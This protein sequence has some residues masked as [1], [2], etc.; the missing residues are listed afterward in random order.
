MSQKYES[1]LRDSISKLSLG[2][3]DIVIVT[4]PEAMSTFVEMTQAGVGFSGYANPVLYVPGG[5][6]KATREDLLDALRILD[7]TAKGT[8]PQTD[9]ASRIIT[10]LHQPSSTPIRKVQ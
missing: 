4:S 10:D 9:E 2:P 8:G 3:H 6:E 7:E 5:L 1:I